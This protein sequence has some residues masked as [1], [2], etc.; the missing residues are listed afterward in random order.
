MRR[1]S[2]GL[3]YP[4]SPLRLGAISLA[5]TDRSKS[6]PYVYTLIASQTINVSAGAY[7][8]A[9]H[10]GVDFVRNLASLITSHSSLATTWRYGEGGENS[11]QKFFL[12]HTY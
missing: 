2:D 8:N 1:Y 5:R 11:T 10:F 12:K 6:C 9:K 4:L 3:N 7:V